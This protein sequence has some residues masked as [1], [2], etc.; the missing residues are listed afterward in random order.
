MIFK[1]LDANVEI[2]FARVCATECPVS[3]V[4]DKFFTPNDPETSSQ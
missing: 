2:E 3:A 1:C 4:M